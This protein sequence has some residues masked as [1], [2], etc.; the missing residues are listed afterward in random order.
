MGATISLVSAVFGVAEYLP[1]FLKSL[2]T[3]GEAL[4][5][6]E[7]IFVDDGSPD[8]SAAIITAWLAEHPQ[9]D[10][11][12]LRQ[13]NGGAAAARNL[14]IAQA[15]GE[16]LSTPDPDDMLADGYLAEILAAIDAADDDVDLIVA[17]MLIF[18]DEY[19]RVNTSHGLD[20]RFRAGARVTNLVDEPEAIQLAT[21]SAF[22]RLSRVK[23]AGLTMPTDVRP[24]F[25][26]AYFLAQY[27][28]LSEKP[29]LSL[30]PDARYLYR[31]GQGSSLV[32]DSWA[33]PEKYT[34]LVEHGYLRLLQSAP[35]RPIWLQNLVLYDIHW[36]YLED[37]KPFFSR[38]AWLP[39]DLAAEFHARIAQLFALIDAD[40]VRDYRVTRL[41]ADLRQSFLIG[42]QSQRPQTFRIAYRDRRA[43]LMRLAYYTGTDA[44]DERVE[45][46]GKAVETV[47]TKSQ[48]FSYLRRVLASERSLWV[49][50]GK[51]AKLWVDGVEYPLAESAKEPRAAN[52]ELPNAPVRVA[53]EL[54]EY[55]PPAEKPQPAFADKLAK[56]VNHLPWVKA[57]YRDAWVL[58][59]REA[60]A[61]DNAEHLQ[62]YLQN[63]R[64]DIN[65]WLVLERTSPDWPRLHRDGYRLVAHGSFKHRQVMLN[66]SHLI[67]SQINPETLYPFGKGLGYEGYRF[68]FL[69]HGVIH[70]DISRWINPKPISLLI[71]STQAE[72]DAVAGEHTPYRF[73]GKNTALTGMARFDRLEAL[74]RKAG[75]P[76]RLLV[77]PSWR[78]W[79]EKGELAPGQ[80]REELFAESP[81]AQAWYELLASPELQ[82]LAAAHQLQLTFQPHPNAK[83]FWDAYRPLPDH[84]EV[85]Y[86]DTHDV[87][88]LLAETALL[89][90]DYSSIAFDAVF[91]SRPVAYY[92]FD[93]DEFFAGSHLVRPG[94]WTY[95]KDGF[96]PVCPD[97]DAT[98]RALAALLDGPLPEPYAS[99]IAHAFP[100]RDLDA[101]KRI[102]SAIE[103]L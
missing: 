4:A 74:A 56:L 42:Y 41:P 48:D 72:Y 100:F 39:E 50:L 75:P 73:S 60:E 15:T 44:T 62:R 9:L 16:W 37:Q 38:T 63:V 93:A 27:L 51:T 45:V 35:T 6:C 46:D 18:N 19:G 25:E 86:Y 14:G 68:T 24:T 79:L 82:A 30:R 43:K 89:L 67:S 34:T 98:L 85:V 2:A 81:Y 28:L 54:I 49:P 94:A 11:R 65:A 36:A 58:I 26:D 99:R 97:L 21:N 3:Q 53:G 70:N 17:R 32:Q 5:R 103:Q 7:L 64:K 52:A 90:T 95:A 84:V 101:R 57:R 12:L 78:R 10:G 80:S 31:R 13:P 40:T 88:L 76:N 47:Y 8:D 71:T 96:G 59:D 22:L 102:V 87:Q 91:I 61:H 20:R 69:Q 66:A 55:S 29:T 33:K 23:A 1:A 83:P 77:A 92:Q